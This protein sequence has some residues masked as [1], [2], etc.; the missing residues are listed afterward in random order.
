M[1][2]IINEVKKISLELMFIKRYFTSMKEVLKNIF[3]TENLVLFF[4]CILLLCGIFV[5]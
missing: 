2:D 4:V 5:T 3:S 1:A